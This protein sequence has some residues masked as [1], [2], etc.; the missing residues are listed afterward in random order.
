MRLDRSR[1]MLSAVTMVCGFVVAMLSGLFEHSSEA[2]MLGAKSFGYPWIWRSNIVQ[3]TTESIIRFG[4][5]AAD[6]AFWSITLFI[7]LLLV[8]RFALKRADSLLNDKRFAVSA[9]MLM[10]MGVLMGLIHELG[11]FF[12]GTALGGTLSYFQMGFLELYPK[13][14]IAS[15]FRLGSVIITGLSSPTQQGLF[16]LAGSSTASVAALV[17]GMLIY[18]TKLGDRARLSLKILGVFGLLDMPFYVAFPSLGLRH[19]ILLGENQSEPLIGAQQLGIP[20]PIF[21]LVISIITVVLILLY[22]K[23]ARI[24]TIEVAKEIKRTLKKG[25]D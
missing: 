18:I 12:A 4:N 5:L 21:Y 10:P 2:G 17:I 25:G 3:S 9:I 16:L 8:E 19:W 23:W 20:D 24:S 6:T 14:T 13:L 22:C 15:Q 1:V 11:H 7:V